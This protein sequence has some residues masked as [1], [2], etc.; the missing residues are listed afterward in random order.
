[1]TCFA[2]LDVSHKMTATC[3]V[4]NDG[5]SCGSPRG[6]SPAQRPGGPITAG[7]A[8]ALP[9]LRPPALSSLWSLPPPMLPRFWVGSTDLNVMPQALSIDKKMRT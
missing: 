2:G 1:M 3:V 5:C 4:D 6:R 8:I 7:M 9:I